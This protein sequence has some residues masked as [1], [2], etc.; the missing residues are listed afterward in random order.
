MGAFRKSV[1]LFV[2]C[3]L[4]LASCKSL[5]DPSVPEPSS[6][7]TYFST[8]QFLTD[9]IMMLQGKIY[10]LEKIIELN[11]QRDSTIV[12]LPTENWAP[13]YAAFLNADIGSTRLLGK[14][15][16]SEFED[17]MTLTHSYV[18]E[19][20]E[21]NLPVR[22]LMISANLE[23]HRIKSFLAEVETNSFW[24]SNRRK[25]YYAPLK[26]IQIQ[27][28]NTPLVGSAKTFRAEYRFLVNQDDNLAE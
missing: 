9:Q 26:V 28:W 6:G 25:L 4:L 13:V 1:G 17:P 7:G 15:R 20:D 16:F 22:R 18:Y 8:A 2:S 19:A 11:G 23:T 24:N 10:T 5:T 14:Y 12:A 27:E 3:S 21:P